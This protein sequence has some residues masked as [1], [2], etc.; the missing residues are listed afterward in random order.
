[1]SKTW[2]SRQHQARGGQLGQSAR[3]IHVALDRPGDRF[4]RGNK[5]PGLADGHL[6]IFVTDIADD[7]GT[8]PLG[9]SGRPLDRKRSG[10][11]RRQECGGDAVA[12]IE[13]LAP[14]DGEGGDA[15]TARQAER[16]RNVFL[17]DIIAHRGGRDCPRGC[18]CRLCFRG[19]FR[20]PARQPPTTTARITRRTNARIVPAFPDVPRPAFFRSSHCSSVAWMSLSRGAAVRR[21]C[22]TPPHRRIPKAMAPFAA[23]DVYPITV[24]SDT[25][26]GA[27]FQG[28][29]AG[30]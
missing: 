17:R 30:L 15:A 10:R 20:L 11:A 1:M 23:Q 5:T 26:Q 4:I 3:G 19:T 2:S 12:W 21:A 25:I 24:H 16:Q 28:I 13:K 22:A 27:E 29:A 9:D 6:W 7:R 8:A 18:G 14:A